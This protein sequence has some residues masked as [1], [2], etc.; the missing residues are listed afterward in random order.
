MEGPLRYG[1]QRKQGGLPGPGTEHTRP[2]LSPPHVRV[3][4]QSPNLLSAGLPQLHTVDH[5]ERL[6]AQWDPGSARPLVSFFCPSLP[7]SG[8]EMHP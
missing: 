5:H 3:A 6:A 8:D 7:S 1:E 4:V 2:P